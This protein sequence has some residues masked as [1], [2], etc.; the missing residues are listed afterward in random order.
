M[1]YFIIAKNGYKNIEL[2]SEGIIKEELD[3]DIDFTIVNGNTWSSI[4]DKYDIE[5]PSNDIYNIK[6]YF[7][8]K[9]DS[10]VCK[11]THNNNLVNHSLCSLI[12]TDVKKNLN[13]KNIEVFGV[14]K[15]YTSILSLFINP[16]ISK[17][18]FKENFIVKLNN[19]EI[20]DSIKSFRS[21][22]S[23]NQLLDDNSRKSIELSVELKEDF[24]LL[25]DNNSN[26]LI[27]SNM[28]FDHIIG[29]K[30]IENTCYMNSS[31]QCLFNC[32]ELSKLLVNSKF[33]N[34]KYKNFVKVYRTNLI[35]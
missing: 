6:I 9:S 14:E 10:C 29:L 23:N 13:I 22:F 19:R 31:L 24:N 8:C 5:I 25:I 1:D 15:I 18:L 30:N 21:L 11:N 27:V 20:V 35:R 28:K 16:T 12:S 17:E 32:L 2:L 4:K 33:N 34:N 7:L 3:R 26:S